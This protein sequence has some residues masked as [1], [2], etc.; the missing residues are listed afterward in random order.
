M[1][2]LLGDT[3]LPGRA[4]KLPEPFVREIQ[5]ARPEKILFTG[6]A[7][8]PSVID[9]LGKIAPVIN[10]KGNMDALAA[11]AEAVIDWDAKIL[12]LHGHSI[13]PRGDHTKLEALAVSKSCKLVVTGH[14]HKPEIW[15]GDKAII[16]NPGSATGAWPGGEEKS[17]PPSFMLLES[18]QRLL[19]VTL[20]SLE[21]PDLKSRNWN[22]DLSSLY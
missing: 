8:I 16:L 13:N 3:H 5:K 6:D 7:V 9:E 14:T 4:T 18:N 15:K 11:P 2:V 20:Y 1:I 21:G 19:R 12:L 22:L 10:V 17:C